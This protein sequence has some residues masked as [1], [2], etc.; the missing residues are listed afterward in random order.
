MTLFTLLPQQYFVPF[1][2]TFRM[3]RHLFENLNIFLLIH[4]LNLT[5]FMLKKLF[6]CSVFLILTQ[7]LSAQTKLPIIKA[8]SASAKIKDGDKI[9]G[10]S[11]SPEA[12]PDVFEANRSRKTK[13]V[14]F[15]TD[16]DSITLA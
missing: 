12:K 2:L 13:K 10:W 11:L 9:T 1:L 16:I 7:Q 4:H 15:Y 5:L 14:T 8:T 6:Y 3:K